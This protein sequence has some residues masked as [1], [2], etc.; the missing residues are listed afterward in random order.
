MQKRSNIINN[1]EITD[2]AGS[3]TSSW[4]CG[5]FWVKQ[6]KSNMELNDLYA[7]I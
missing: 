2:V 6:K 7:P 3:T 4:R 1:L 5:V